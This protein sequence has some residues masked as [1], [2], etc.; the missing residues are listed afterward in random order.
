VRLGLQQAAEVPLQLGCLQ[1]GGISFVTLTAAHLRGVAAEHE[2]KAY[3][4]GLM[5]LVSDCHLLVLLDGTC[6]P[7]DLDVMWTLGLGGAAAPLA[8]V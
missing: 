7:Q 5:Q 6:D 8:V 2:L 1:A 3:A 4:Q